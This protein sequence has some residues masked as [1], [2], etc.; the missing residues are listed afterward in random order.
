MGNQRYKNYSEFLRSKEWQE[1]K[2]IVIARNEK[3]YGGMC[4]RC[5]DN[6]AIDTHHMTYDFGWNPPIQFLRRLCRKCHRF[7]HR[8]SDYDP[9]PD[10]SLEELEQRFTQ[11]W[12]RSQS[13]ICESDEE[14]IHWREIYQRLKSPTPMCETCEDE[15]DDEETLSFAEIE[16]RLE[17]I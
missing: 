2:N 14:I 5:L 11:M 3:Y 15:A 1:T 17:G 16:K 6:K 4:E 10:L 13:T 8:L 12:E 9:M 7:I